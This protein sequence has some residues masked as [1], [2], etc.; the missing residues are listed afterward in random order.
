MFPVSIIPLLAALALLA[1]CQSERTALRRALSGQPT[2]I[3]GSLEGGW[4]VADLNGGGM[5]AGVRLLFDAGD[6]GTSRVS[7]SSGCNR[8][9]GSWAQTGQGV[10][11]SGIAATKMACPGPAMDTE[12]RLLALLAAVTSVTYTAAG[13]AILAVPDGRKLTLRRPA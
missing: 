6:H 4:V 2:V 9:S 11:L 8:F 7:G 3:A 10:E 5:P 13:D 12:R 1:G